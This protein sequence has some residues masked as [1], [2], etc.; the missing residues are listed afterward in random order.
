MI[1]RRVGVGGIQFIVQRGTVAKIPM[2]AGDGRVPIAVAAVVGE[3]TGET[4]AVPVE[5]RERLSVLRL[6][7]IHPVRLRIRTPGQSSPA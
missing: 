7:R 1:G 4:L 2:A 5:V 3:L 6:R